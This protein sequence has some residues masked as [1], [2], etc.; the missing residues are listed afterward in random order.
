MTSEVEFKRDR[1][2]NVNSVLTQLCII[3]LTI[4]ISMVLK[5]MMKSQ[6]N[7]YIKTG[8]RIR[9]STY[10]LTLKCVGKTQHPQLLTAITDPVRFY[11]H[12]PGR[13]KLP[14]TPLNL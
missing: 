5:I 2:E 14:F 3:L 11:L 8:L 12:T 13:Q 4:N 10:L 7:K 9:S 6:S 1:R